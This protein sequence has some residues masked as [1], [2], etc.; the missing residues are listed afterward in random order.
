MCWASHSAQLLA[1]R[2][3]IVD[4]AREWFAVNL[5]VGMSGLAA[6]ASAERVVLGGLAC[7][8]C[9]YCCC[10][11]GGG[12]GGGELLPGAVRKVRLNVTR[13]LATARW[14]TKG[15][16]GSSCGRRKQNANGT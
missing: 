7:C 2:L 13:L 14:D 12:G 15:L 3:A 8:C 5:V 16:L 6:F 4:G 9:C 11:G 10:C 1:V